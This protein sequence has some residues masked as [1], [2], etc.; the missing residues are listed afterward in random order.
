MVFGLYRHYKGHWY[1]G[2]WTYLES[3]NDQPRERKV[4][5]FSFGKREFDGRRMSEFFNWIEIPLDQDSG[6]GK[7]FQKYVYRFERIF[8]PWQPRCQPR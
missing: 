4:Q 1:L 8:P 5:Y 7:V 2:L 6:I 3:T